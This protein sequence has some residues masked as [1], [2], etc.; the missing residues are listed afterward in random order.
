MS[1]LVWSVTWSFRLDNATANDVAQTVWLRLIENC[2]RIDAPER[3]PGWIA[4]TCRREAMR[5]IAQM[6]KAVPSEFEYEVADASVDLEADIVHNE[7][8]DAVKE[9]FNT[10]SREDQQ[11]LR[12]LV[13]E[14]PL[15]YEEISKV[16]GRPIGSLGPTRARSLGRLRRA[17]E[18]TPQKVA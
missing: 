10:L 5:V 11:L 3:L 13:V 2:H 8:H 18:R 16:T 12:L 7:E 6:K 15:T 17:M 9:A 4:T 14:P 1:P